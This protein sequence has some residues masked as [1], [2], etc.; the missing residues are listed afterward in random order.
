MEKIT[1]LEYNSIIKTVINNEAT[2][3]DFSDKFQ[4]LN[5]YNKAINKLNDLIDWKIFLPTIEKCFYKENRGIGGRPHYDYILMFKILILQ[6]IYNLSDEAIEYEII[7]RLDFMNFLNISSETPDR[8]TIWNFREVLTNNNVI[9]DLFNIFFKQLK[10]KNLIMNEGT[11]VDATFVKVP[12]QRNSFDENKEIKEGKT[13]EN[14]S[15][16]HKISQKDIDA[17]W[18]IKRN[19]VFYGYKNHIK[20][21][22]TNKFIIGSITTTAK[23]HDS[24]MISKLINDEDKIIYADATYV[25]TERTLSNKTEKYFCKRGYRNKPLSQKD[26]EY[27][28]KVSS[29]RCRIEHVFATMKVQMNNAINIR[30]IGLKRARFMVTLTNLT[31]NILRFISLSSSRGTV[32]F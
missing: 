15:N 13:P 10:E 17:S 5:N 18:T 9:D 8:N 21:D 14:W 31:Y 19:E 2:F 3:F 28:K 1:L 4:K 32:P 24:Q 29:I 25:G 22:K 7:N 20:I 12:K 23:I 30:T 16:V 11:I 6:R 26:K 27:N